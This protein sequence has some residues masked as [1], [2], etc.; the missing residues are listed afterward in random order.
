MGF[1]TY[2][3]PIILP[4]WIQRNRD[5]RTTKLRPS[6]LSRETLIKPPISGD[7]CLIFANET[8]WSHF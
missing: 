1:E 5:T 4:P 8:S 3:N 7:T 2:A 6:P